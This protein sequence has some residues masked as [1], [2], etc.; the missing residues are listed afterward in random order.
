MSSERPVCL[1]TGG[2]SGIGAAC[3]RLFVDAGYTVLIGDIQ[4]KKGEEL[5]ASLGDQAAFIELN[6]REEADFLRATSEAVTR[7][8]HLDCL[9][10][11]AAIVGTLGPIAE[12]PL[13]EFDFTT[14]II[15]RSVFLGMKH[16]ARVMGPQGS[17][18]IVNIASVAGLLGGY[19][20]HLY[21]TSKAAVVQLT[22]SVSLE[23]IEQGIRVN[24]VCPGNVETPI[25]TGVTDERW[26]RRMEKIRVERA[27]DQPIGRMAQPEEIAE[28]VLWLASPQSSYVTGHAMVV[29]GGLVAGPSWRHQPPYLREFHAAKR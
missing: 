4:V 2:A 6:V 15:L 22:R 8:G 26:M 24:A 14:S 28:A 16:A 21:N 12:I 10:N 5:A 11:N 19:G 25:H 7:Y 20:P 27:N 18:N 23:L 3:A 29:D 13:E 1:I 9:V 17:G